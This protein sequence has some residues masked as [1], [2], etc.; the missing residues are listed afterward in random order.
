MLEIRNLE[1]ALGNKQV[2]FELDLT[3]QQRGI[4]LGLVGKNG[5]GKQPR[6]LRFWI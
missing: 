3:A 6:I 2:L 4:S 5:A 1:K